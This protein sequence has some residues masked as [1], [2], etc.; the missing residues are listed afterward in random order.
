MESTVPGEPTG[1]SD[2]AR[3]ERRQ[4]AG[5]IRGPKDSVPRRYGHTRSQTRR[6]EQVSSALADSASSDEVEG[7]TGIH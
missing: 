1:E 4:L 3:T 6:L 7:S 2:T 5:A